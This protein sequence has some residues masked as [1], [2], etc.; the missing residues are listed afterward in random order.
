MPEL[1]PLPVDGGVPDDVPG[2][3]LLPPPMLPLEPEVLP[4]PAVPL[5]PDEYCGQPGVVAAFG[6]LQSGLLVL[7][8]LVPDDMLPEPVVP[9][10]PD[11]PLLLESEVP[12]VELLAP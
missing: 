9:V 11:V 6:P 5:V 10:V 12:G 3:M 2:L 7:P 1:L 8:P 4:A